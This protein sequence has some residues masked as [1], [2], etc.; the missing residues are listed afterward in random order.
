MTRG[1][2]IEMNLIAVVMSMMLYSSCA[3]NFNHWLLKQ[4]EQRYV[5][6]FRENFEAIAVVDWQGVIR[7]VNQSFAVLFSDQKVTFIFTLL[8]VIVC[9]YC[10]F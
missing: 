6:F 7:E 3:H 5:Q 2:H 1:L 4:N 10:R 8:I 9:Y